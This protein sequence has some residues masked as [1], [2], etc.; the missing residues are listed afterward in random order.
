MLDGWERRAGGGPLH[1]DVAREMMAF[2]LHVTNERVKRPY[3]LSSWVPTPGNVRFRRAM[4]VLDGVVAALI[5]GRRRGEARDDL[6]STLI[7]AR[8]PGRAKG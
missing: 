6:L 5:Q 4:R 8:D 7:E 2:T 3:D 1:L